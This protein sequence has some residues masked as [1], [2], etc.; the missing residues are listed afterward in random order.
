ME[1][2]TRDLRFVV[3]GEISAPLRHAEGHSVRKLIA[4]Y[5]EALFPGIALNIVPLHSCSQTDSR[6][7]TSK[8]CYGSS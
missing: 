7:T 5:V 2:N 1:L 6:A 3:Q 4:G 8:T